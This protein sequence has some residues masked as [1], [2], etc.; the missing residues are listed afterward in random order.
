MIVAAFI[1]ANSQ[2]SPWQ[3][4]PFGGFAPCS[5]CGSTGKTGTDVD[6]GIAGV[7][8]GCPF[9]QDPYY[10]AQTTAYR[11]ARTNAGPAAV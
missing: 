3:I 2:E 10:G 4:D 1:L 8:G 6:G 9:D 11:R 5:P 7:N